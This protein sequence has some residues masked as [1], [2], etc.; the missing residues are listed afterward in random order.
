MKKRIVIISAVVLLI[1]VGVLQGVKMVL[2]V[3]A[4]AAALVCF[5][6]FIDWFL[7][8]VGKP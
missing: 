7:N 1:T 6:G 8:N 3:I 4:G 2:V 5:C